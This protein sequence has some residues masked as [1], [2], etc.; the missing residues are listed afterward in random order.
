MFGGLGGD[1][2][3]L[4]IGM[5]TR[6]NPP[7]RVAGSVVARGPQPPQKTNGQG[8]FGKLS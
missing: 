7:A 8:S 1:V 2:Q 6:T 5:G 3:K 4:S